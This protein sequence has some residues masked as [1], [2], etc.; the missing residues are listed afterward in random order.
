[1]FSLS[2]EDSIVKYKFGD[3]MVVSALR[4]RWASWAK[5]TP[6][7][8]LSVLVISKSLPVRDGLD[9]PLGNLISVLITSLVYACNSVC[10]CLDK[11]FVLQYIAL[12]N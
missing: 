12:V 10:F 6:G 4:H 9:C 5:L 1:M 2:D 11:G 7:L 3:V 8:C